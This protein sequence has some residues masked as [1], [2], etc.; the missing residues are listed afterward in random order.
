MIPDLQHGIA[1]LDA[2]IEYLRQ[3]TCVLID[4]D[5]Q[6]QDTF[7]LLIGVTGIADASA[8][9]LSVNPEE[10]QARQWGAMAG[11]GQPQLQ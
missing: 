1:R 2:K 5:E 4:T 8:I 7:E 3:Q 10:M 6:L 11:L 9:Q